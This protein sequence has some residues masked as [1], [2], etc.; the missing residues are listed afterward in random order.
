MHALSCVRARWFIRSNS[1]VQAG[2]LARP[3]VIRSLEIE[4]MLRG[5]LSASTAT[6]MVALSI[7]ASNTFLALLFQWSHER[8]VFTRVDKSFLLYTAVVSTFMV[9]ALFTD[10]EDGA[11]A[12]A[13][14]GASAGFGSNTTGS[15]DADD[16]G[17]T[18]TSTFSSLL[19]NIFVGAFIANAFT[20]PV[21]Y[22][23]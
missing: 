18:A 17:V 7:V 13:G 23:K 10:F 22:V 19:L 9:Q 12:G 14:A 6:G 21:K 4:A 20:F 16:S 2:K 1:Y 8:I 15:A 3:R 11:G 5:W